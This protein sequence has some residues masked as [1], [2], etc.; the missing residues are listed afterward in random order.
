MNALLHILKKSMK[1]R[2]LEI[3]R[4]PAKLVLYLLCIGGVGALIVI[5]MFTNPQSTATMDVI[6]LKG[7]YFIFVMMFV[8]IAVQ[9]GLSNGDII[10]EMQDVNLLFVSPISPKS[11]LMYGLLQMTKMAFWA[12]FFILFQGSWIGSMFG[13]GFNAILILFVNFILTVVFLSI[14]SLVLYNLTNGRPRRKR[15]VRIVAIIVFLPLLSFIGI[16][17]M[18]TQDIM[19]ALENVMRSP[20][21]SWTPIA[22]WSAG[23]AIGLIV[24]DM[25]AGIL[26]MAISVLVG[27]MMVAY[28]LLG[29]IDYYE[30]VLVATETAFEKKRAI[31][32]GQVNPEALSGRKT[33]VAKTG[34]TGFGA[35]VFFYKHLRET[36]RAN[37]LGLLTWPTVFMI[38]GAAVLAFFMRSEGS[39]IMTILQILMW[40]Q[41]FMIGMGRGLK[42]LSTHY[43]YLIP[44]S[45]FRKIVW[46]N[47]EPAAKVFLESVLLFAIAGLI[48]NEPL[49][50][51]IGSIL[52][53]TLFSLM[54]IGINFLS[55]RWLGTEISAGILIMLY[56][57]AVLVFL[58]PGLIPAVILGYTLEGIWGTIVGLGILAIWELIAAI[59]CFILAKGVLHRC[60][61]QQIQSK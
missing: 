12:G 3:I 35:N 7:F 60:D 17:L 25:S 23:A 61:I 58:L 46:S 36:T 31:A 53:F 32:E 45:S 16:E 20:M 30:D 43:I 40:M 21:F 13:T 56:I 41:V 59:I 5:S 29:N 22:G 10:F 38:L 26:F 11:I 15:F 24:G 37:S 54:L 49:L 2:L 14:L 34:I 18:Q 48:S 39:A 19:L 42:E 55:M 6:W 1:N 8:V 28:I 51:I 52:V 27:G 44:E 9:R 33:K 57:I 4:K 50:I 47:L